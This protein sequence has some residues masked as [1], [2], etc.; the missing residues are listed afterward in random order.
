MT[1]PKRSLSVSLP[2]TKR[3]FGELKVAEVTWVTAESPTY[4]RSEDSCIPAIP[5]PEL[6]ALAMKNNTKNAIG[7]S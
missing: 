1:R 2:L 6:A 5:W 7:S 3:I 4:K